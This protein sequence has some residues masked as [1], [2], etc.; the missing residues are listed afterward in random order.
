ML[1]RDLNISPQMMETY[2]LEDLLIYP[3]AHRLLIVVEYSTNEESSPQ[4]QWSL[5]VCRQHESNLKL[6]NKTMFIIPYI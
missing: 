1:I 5:L 4:T 3:L 6:K 2:T